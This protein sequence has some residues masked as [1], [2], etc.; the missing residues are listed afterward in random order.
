[1]H[2]W[3]SLIFIKYYIPL[4]GIN[5]FPFVKLHVFLFLCLPILYN[6]YCQRIFFLNNSHIDK[7]WKKDEEKMA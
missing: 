2:K 3:G 5:K 7:Q 1:M 4:F 6:A